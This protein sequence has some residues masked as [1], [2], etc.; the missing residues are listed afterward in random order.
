M[1]CLALGKSLN[2]T[3]LPLTHLELIK[4]QAKHTQLTIRTT[5]QGLALGFQL[6][7]CDLFFFY[8]LLFSVPIRPPG[9]SQSSE[10][11][12][13]SKCMKQIRKADTCPS[14]SLCCALPLQCP[15]VPFQPPSCH[16]SQSWEGWREGTEPPLRSLIST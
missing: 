6:A 1:L 16:Q 7:T 9:P 5:E 14:P 4:C 11:I 8:D 10:S 12:W 13:G 15:Q 3:R 2:E